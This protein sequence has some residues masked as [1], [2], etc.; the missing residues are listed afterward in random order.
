MNK[1]SNLHG[2]GA[3]DNSHEWQIWNLKSFTLVYIWN[4]EIP[5][6][7]SE[8]SNPRKLGLKVKTPHNSTRY[9]TVTVSKH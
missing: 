3:M 5:A 8:H 1:P 6:S 2:G 4:V 7:I 9:I